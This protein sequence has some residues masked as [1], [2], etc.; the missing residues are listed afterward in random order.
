VE[1]KGLLSTC[2]NHAMFSETIAALRKYITGVGYDYNGATILT[3]CFTTNLK[4]L[5]KWLHISDN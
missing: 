5:D 4:D 3:V 2:R 1:L